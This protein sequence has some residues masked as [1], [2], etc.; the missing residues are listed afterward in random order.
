M[1]VQQTIPSNVW[2]SIN[3]LAGIPVGSEMEVTVTSGYSIQVWEGVQPTT[4]FRGGK[5]LS[6]M[7]LPYATVSVTADSSEIWG[8]CT[9]DGKEARISVSY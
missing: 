5:P 8:I 9:T 7:K 6:N 3:A 1:S 4:D 2:V